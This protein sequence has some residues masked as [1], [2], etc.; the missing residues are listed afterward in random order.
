MPKLNSI[1]YV[2]TAEQV[3]IKLKD[4]GKGKIS[5]TT[6]KIRNLLAMVSELQTD[7][8]YIMNDKLTSDMQSR[9]QYLKMRIAYEAGRELG[10]KQ[11]V[12]NAN[13]LEHISNIKD[14]KHELV[15]FCNYMEALVAYHRYYGGRD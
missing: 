1:T 8:K 10:V 14:S 12:E 9:I 2:D 13:L 5:L 4:L 15:L 3:I 6:S 7:A 11:F